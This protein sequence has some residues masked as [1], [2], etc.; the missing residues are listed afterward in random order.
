MG[1]LCKTQDTYSLLI[2]SKQIYND[3]LKVGLTPNKS[4]TCVFP[5]LNSALN[6]HF[7][8]GYFDGDGS[9]SL[10]FQKSNLYAEI[11][12]VG[13]TQF[14]KGSQN[15]F[16]VLDIKSKISHDKR[17]K[18]GID[19]LRIRDIKS[20]LRFCKY[21]YHESTIHLERK[22]QKFKCFLKQRSYVCPL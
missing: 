6:P 15:I 21:I 11:C 9:I 1:K 14:C 16:N 18:A 10:S 2:S 19:S 17:V 5:T 22:H 8:R 20:I 7:M 4:F 12:I 13:S 3:L